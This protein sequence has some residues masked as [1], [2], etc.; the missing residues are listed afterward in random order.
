MLLSLLLK[1][2]LALSPFCF[3]QYQQ[4]NDCIPTL[5][6]SYLH[7]EYGL[8]SW[9]NAVSVQKLNVPDLVVI[10]QLNQQQQGRSY[11]Q[12]HK[13]QNINIHTNNQPEAASLINTQDLN[14]NDQQ[15]SQITFECLISFDKRK[16]KNLIIKWHHDDRVEPIYQWI[17]ELNKRSIAPQYRAYIAPIVTAASQQQSQQAIDSQ[18]TLSGLN[19]NVS[20]TNFNLNQTQLLEAGFKLVR[21]S[22]ELGGKFE[23]F[24]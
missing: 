17:P 5:N 9:V 13:T 21:P 18:S 6:Y 12:V 14:S 2:K 20:S 1:Q 3:P 7:S 23:D 8:I 11:D 24:F 15:Q 19:Q 4:T 10:D 16:D 22:K